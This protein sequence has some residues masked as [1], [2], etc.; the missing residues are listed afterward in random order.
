ML[1]ELEQSY[2]MMGCAR[3]IQISYEI[4]YK[5]FLL[6]LGHSWKDR[7]NNGKRK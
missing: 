7:E 1:F 2:G 6:L 3:L 4:I 5:F